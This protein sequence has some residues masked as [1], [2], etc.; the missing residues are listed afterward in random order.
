MWE[1][2]FGVMCELFMVWTDE[3]GSEEDDEEDLADFDSDEP[4]VFH[5]D[6]GNS[7]DDADDDDNEEELFTTTEAPDGTVTTTSTD[8]EDEINED[9][10]TTDAGA[11]VT[12]SDRASRAEESS[13]KGKSSRKVNRR[14]NGGGKKQKNG[15]KDNMARYNRYV[16]LVFKRMNTL[17]RSKRMDPLRVNL[18]AGSNNNNGSKNNNNSNSSNNNPKRSGSQG[19]P[20]GGKRGGRPGS[21]YSKKNKNNNDVIGQRRAHQ[22]HRAGGYRPPRFEVD[23][24]YVFEYVP[25]VSNT[26]MLL[27][28]LFCLLQSRLLMKQYA[29]NFF[30]RNPQTGSSRW[31]QRGD[32][33]G[34]QNATKLIGI[35]E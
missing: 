16:D 21:K 11:T 5:E 17:I 22:K 10:K 25:T 33:H 27:L 13:T 8:V 29:D 19:K 9:G 35:I 12:P 18:Y 32:L 30:Q 3:F 4:D 34:Q 15:K 23:H 14:R 24:P 28:L 20:Q 7:S 6:A 31:Q 1:A 26:F 2:V